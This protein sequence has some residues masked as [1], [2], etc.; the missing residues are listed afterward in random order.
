MSL[1]RLFP[2]MCLMLLGIACLPRAAEAID[3]SCPSEIKICSPSVIWLSGTIERGDAKK[4]AD[5]IKRRGPTVATVALID[6][7]G[8]DL[9]E[10]I[11]IGRLI[12]K[13]QLRTT[14][15]WPIFGSGFTSA[16]GLS[17]KIYYPMAAIVGSD[18]L[19]AVPS[20]DT[21][22]A[23][24]ISACVDIWVAGS[25]RFGTAF[26]GIHKFYLKAWNRPN[27]TVDQIV[28]ATQH[29]QEQVFAYYSEMGVPQSFIRLQNDTPWNDLQFLKRD[30]IQSKFLG[31]TIL[32]DVW[33]KWS[34][35]SLY[36]NWE[37]VA[38]LDISLESVATLSICDEALTREARE[39][40]W[41]D[42]FDQ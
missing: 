39:Q 26:L 15:G 34:C 17:R 16:Y 8:G 41:A 37:D 20:V 33:M 11:R 25:Q 32:R 38:Q 12:R 27:V 21:S 35:G 29:L 2:V 30:F 23:D 31:Q 24:C 42:V 22:R 14:V 3:L 6:S 9:R 13:L 18:S 19:P 7:P 1:V 28:A 10:A 36:P 5:E 4:F 40:A